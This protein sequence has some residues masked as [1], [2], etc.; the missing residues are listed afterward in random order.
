[1]GYQVYKVGKRW[2]GYGVQPYP[3]KPESKLWIKHY[4][5]GLWN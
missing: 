5:E 2:G 3:Y 1:M 4:M